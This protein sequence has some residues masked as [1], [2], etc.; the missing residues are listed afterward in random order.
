MVVHTCRA[1]VFRY[2]E[3]KT[4]KCNCEFYAYIIKLCLRSNVITD[5]AKITVS[6]LPGLK[7][8]FKQNNFWE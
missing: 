6:Y 8:Y 3:L 5:C 2:K 7:I 1:D 4:E